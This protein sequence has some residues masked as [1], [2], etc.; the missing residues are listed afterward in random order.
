[1]E[2]LDALLITPQYFDVDCS[3]PSLWDWS[4]G[5]QISR[6]DYTRSEGRRRAFA[7]V[8][9]SWRA[10][11]ESRA[12]RSEH[13]TTAVPRSRRITID[14]V[15]V[16]HPCVSTRWE[17]LVAHLA[18]EVGHGTGHFR[19]IAQNIHLHKN[20][21]RIDLR[22]AGAIHIPDLMHILP[23]FS[24]LVCLSVVLDDAAG[25]SLPPEPISLP[26]LNSLI[27][28]TPYIRQYPHELFEIPSLVNLHFTVTGDAPSF[29]ELLYPYHGTLK[30]LGI[31]WG[32]HVFLT[33][34]QTLP[35]WDF[36]PRL[37]EL[38]LDG[39][40]SR[41]PR[42]TSPP[43]P[44]HP[45]RV[46]RIDQITWPI[47]D[48]LLPARDD[49]DVVERNAIRKIAI[50]TL[51]WTSGGYRNPDGYQLFDQS[52]MARV[53][54]LAKLC[55]NMGIGLEDVT[56]AY[57]ERPGNTW[58]DFNDSEILPTILCANEGVE[59]YDFISSPRDEEIIFG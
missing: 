55:A 17:I 34:T 48:Q 57:L 3:L 18:D 22:I 53:H 52:E 19:R 46:V 37:E 39:W 11:A 15:K 20:I 30:N 58:S 50:L 1:M 40:G 21:K 12:N 44:T 5:R 59:T 35:G 54:V 56:G 31:C 16:E 7:S 38:V 24:T 26:N 25:L 10:Y 33:T 43:P 42:V 14:D 27:L 47:I 8:C 6:S 45:L 49:P 29:E 51:H 28:K 13:I 9:R 36:F 23:A 2:I 32:G 4:C 41:T